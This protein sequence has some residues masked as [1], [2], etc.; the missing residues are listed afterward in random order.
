MYIMSEENS[1]KWYDEHVSIRQDCLCDRKIEA[2]VGKISDMFEQKISRLE[3]Q[4][5]E[6]KT[7]LIEQEVREQNMLIRKHVPV[8]FIP[9]HT[10]AFS[11][12]R[13]SIV[14]K[15]SENMRRNDS[16]GGLASSEGRVN[17]KYNK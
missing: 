14:T 5:L 8:S 13:T 11:E 17:E 7:K 15:H 16:S 12:I 6:L 4:I 9:S 3:A 1:A 10:A 2:L